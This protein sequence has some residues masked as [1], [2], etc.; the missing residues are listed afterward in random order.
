M[1]RMF[2]L[3]AAALALTLGT[4]LAF[5]QNAAPARGPGFGGPGA[6]AP[7]SG[8]F[9]LKEMDTNDDKVVSKDEFIKH[10]ED[11]FAKMDLDGNG[12]VT[13]EEAKEAHEKMRE[14]IREK[15]QDDCKTRCEGKG[16]GAKQPE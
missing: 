8:L 11:R 5:A 4:G 7:R 10:A 14:E 1:N 6:H 12:E 13:L 16:R 9:Q 15:R 3:G 2:M